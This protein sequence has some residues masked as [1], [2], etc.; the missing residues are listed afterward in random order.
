MGDCRHPW[1]N[2]FIKLRPQR[3]APA[4]SWPLIKPKLDCGM[5]MQR[6]ECNDPCVSRIAETKL[7]R[8][9]SQHNWPVKGV[10]P[11]SMLHASLKIVSAQVPFLHTVQNTTYA[12]HVGDM[13]ST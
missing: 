7:N 13:H 12:A 10:L 9:Q 5:M 2:Y 8:S 6:F 1:T 3:E 11:L 4:K